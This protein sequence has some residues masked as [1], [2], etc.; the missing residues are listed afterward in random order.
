MQTQYYFFCS[1]LILLTS[2]YGPKNERR[3]GS[4]TNPLRTPRM[5]KI[6]KTAKKYLKYSL[7]G[8]GERIAT[9]RNKGLQITA[10]YVKIIQILK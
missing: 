6:A 9:V 4:S 5:V 3:T 7:N 8:L 1:P 2:G 10:T